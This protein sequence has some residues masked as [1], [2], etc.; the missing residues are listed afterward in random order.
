MDR[1]N[2]ESLKSHL[3]DLGATYVTTYDELFGKTFKEKL[4][5]YTMNKAGFFDLEWFD[6]HTKL[7]RTLP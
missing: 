1:E 6:L 2:I 3:M 7:A 5:S 4:K